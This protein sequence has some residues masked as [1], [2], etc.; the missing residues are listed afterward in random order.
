VALDDHAP[1]AKPIVFQFS[2]KYPKMFADLVRVD[3]RKQDDIVRFTKDLLTG[4]DF[5]H[6]HS[7]HWVPEGER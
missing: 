4:P 7:G 6:T 1:D 5:F 3:V 2:D